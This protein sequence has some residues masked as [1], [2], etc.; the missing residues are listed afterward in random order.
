VG[1]EAAAGRAVGVHVG[2][3]A[4]VAVLAGGTGYGL[5]RLAAGGQPVAALVLLLGAAV[6]AV[7][8]LD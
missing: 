8:A 3:S 6:L 5:F 2:A 7:R 1:A 4:V